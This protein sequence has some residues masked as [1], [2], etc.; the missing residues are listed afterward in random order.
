MILLMKAAELFKKQM[1]CS[2]RSS[3]TI[4]GYMTELNQFNTFLTKKYNGPVYIEEVDVQDLEDYIGMLKEKG[5]APASR[6]RSIYILRAFT[7]FCLKRELISKNIG[8]MLEPVPVPEKERIYLTPKDM[9]VLLSSVKAPIAKLVLSTLFYTG[10]RISECLNLRLCDV[11]LK[12]GIISVKNTKN[13]KDRQIPIH[14]DLNTILGE[15]LKNRRT[16]GTSPFFFTSRNKNRVSPDY[17]NRILRET[18]R[19]LRWNKKVTCHILR[20]SFASNLVAK[21]VNIVNIQKLL[22]HSDLSTTSIYTHSNM[23]E[24]TNA[25]NLI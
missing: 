13:K 3:E 18:T 20:H 23:D 8:M 10:M 4:K 24:L 15:Y 12:S 14:K 21:N 9:D 22:G 25:I 17:V 7:S 11:D 19:S 5:N 1:K 6:S 2:D 16:G